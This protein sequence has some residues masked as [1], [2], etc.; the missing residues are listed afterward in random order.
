[1]KVCRFFEY[2]KKQ[3]LVAWNAISEI[4]ENSII[5]FSFFSKV[6]SII[7]IFISIGMI[8]LSEFLYVVVFVFCLSVGVSLLEKPFPHLLV[9]KSGLPCV[10]RGVFKD[11][12]ANALTAPSLD[13]FYEFDTS[14]KASLGRVIEFVL[15]FFLYSSTD[16]AKKR[17]C[18]DKT[19][20]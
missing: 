14:I 10:V 17:S 2:S 18:F 1:M 19:A 9:L 11:R 7:F 8:V 6:N 20:F 3:N 15:A 12:Q 5:A 16:F 4:S 13:V